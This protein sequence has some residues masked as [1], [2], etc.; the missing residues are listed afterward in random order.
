MLITIPPAVLLAAAPVPAA[1][2]LL[3]R[4]SWMRRV[5]QQRLRCIEAASSP[6][7]LERCAGTGWHHDR[8][9]GG[10]GCPLW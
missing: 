6:E 4:R 9:M 2:D 10:W 1:A 7:Q 5:Q 3:E 8:G